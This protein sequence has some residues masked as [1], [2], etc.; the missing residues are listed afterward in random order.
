[1]TTSQE[2]DFTAWEIDDIRRSAELVADGVGIGMD[3]VPD[4]RL[5]VET[6]AL[7]WRDLPPQYRD[8]FAGLAA[9]ALRS[10]GYRVEKLED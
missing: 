9:H 2:Q 5:F 1:M 8:A 3:E 4:P 6:F 10:L 7:N